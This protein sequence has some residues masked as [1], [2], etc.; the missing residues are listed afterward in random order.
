MLSDEYLDSTGQHPQKS[1]GRRAVSQAEA[2]DTFRLLD[3]VFKGAMPLS[4]RRL[5]PRTV[6]PEC[7]VS[8]VVEPLILMSHPMKMMDAVP[9]IILG[10]KDESVN[11]HGISQV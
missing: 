7:N 10:V 11:T 5:I 9:V 6:Q 2:A 3:V 1:L 4:Y 8:P